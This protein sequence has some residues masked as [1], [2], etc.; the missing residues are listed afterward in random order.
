MAIAPLSFHGQTS[1]CPTYEVQQ[2]GDIFTYCG[3]QSAPEMVIPW[4][5][6]GSFDMYVTVEFSTDGSP[7]PIEVSSNANYLSFPGSPTNQQDV[8]ILDGCG[9]D[10]VAYTST[11]PPCAFGSFCDGNPDQS[12]YT[13]FFCLPP[14]TYIAVI[15]YMNA[16]DLPFNSYF[17]QT[18]CI[19]YTFG[20]PS[21]LSLPEGHTVNQEKE[22]NPKQKRYRK[23]IRPQ[24]DSPII[25]D[26]YSGKIRSLQGKKIN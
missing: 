22:Y 7:Y 11:A 4:F 12:I 19:T 6:C 13:A 2:G 26:T 21:F 5:P 23:I 15:G 20:S 1:P 17:Q 9:G 24:D 10:L 8:M 18:G 25:I 14:G 16:T 3:E